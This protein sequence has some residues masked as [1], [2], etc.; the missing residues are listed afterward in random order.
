[1]P[2]IPRTAQESRELEQRHRAFKA[3]QPVEKDGIRDFVLDSWLRCRT[4]F[5]PQVRPTLR[6]LHGREL[7]KRVRD[8]AFVTHNATPVMHSVFALLKGPDAGIKGINCSVFIT[9]NEG[10]TLKVLGDDTM[11]LQAGFVF[12]ER[13]IGSNSVHSCILNRYISTIYG[14]EHYFEEF[15]SYVASASPLITEDGS[16]HG[17]FGVLLHC[18]EYDLSIKAMS[19]VSAK[20]ISSLM[21][22]GIHKSHREFLL[23]HIDDAIIYTNE[24]HK[25]L[26]FNHQS[27]EFFPEI[28]EMDDLATHVQ[29]PEDFLHRLHN[30]APLSNTYITIRNSLRKSISFYVTV[31]YDQFR[32]TTLILRRARKVRELA[33]QVAARGAVYRFDDI[34]GESSALRQTKTLAGKAAGGDMTTL[35]TGE[36]GTGKEL[37]AH[38]IHNAG[39]RADKPF[40][41]VNCGALPQSLVQSELFGYEEG[42][43]TGASLRGK[44]GKFELADGGTIFLDEIGE[45][46]LDVQANLLRFMQSGE[47]SKIG[48]A[49]PQMVNVRVIAATNRE[50]QSL[51]AQGRFRED[52]FYRLNAFPIRIPPLRERQGD[53]VL[54]AEYFAQTFS[55]AVKGRPCPLSAAS[56]AAI[57]ACA[58]P[59]NVRE[60]EYCIQLHVNLMDGN[61]IEIPPLSLERRDQPAHVRVEG[62][63]TQKNSFERQLIAESLNTY[64]GD[65]KQVSAHLNI[66]VSTLYSK[67]KKH[68]LLTLHGKADTQNPDPAAQ[69][70]ELGIL[71]SRLSPNAK[72]SLCNFLRQMAAPS[73][74]G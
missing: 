30:R 48:A 57:A 36:S 55:V 58:W 32:G 15:S 40:L 17:A 19:D 16:V 9:D 41:V 4:Y 47:I 33:T 44:A 22:A 37:F 61:V 29:F 50:L 13:S 31:N 28:K 74:E 11:P 27:R 72:E 51:A 54:L 73:G 7:E 14:F 38:A 69:D 71:L 67:I 46:P 63:E 70:R 5:S 39:S 1:M 24:Q 45:L 64:G 18:Q 66:P 68:G 49:Q 2:D 56:K 25:I 60:L 62:F 20:A 34:L 53:A 21:N 43:F 23:D 3:G 35:I 6:T 42:A 52:L 65:V 59:G 12:D 8:N 26:T 10:V